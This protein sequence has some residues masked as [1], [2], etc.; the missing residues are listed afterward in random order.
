MSTVW[1]LLDMI[2]RL[3]SL[4]DKTINGEPIQELDQA[5]FIWK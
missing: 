4:K 1:W 2:A 3:P 5:V